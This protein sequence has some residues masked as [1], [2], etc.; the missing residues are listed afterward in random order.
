[1][2]VVQQVCDESGFSRVAVAVTNLHGPFLPQMKRKLRSLWDLSPSP[3]GAGAAAVFASA[4][5][6]LESR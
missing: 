2:Q 1:M 3:S 4:S 6:L 5:F